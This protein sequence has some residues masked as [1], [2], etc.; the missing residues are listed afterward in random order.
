M[1]WHVNTCDFV[2][3]VVVVVGVDILARVVF[4]WLVALSKC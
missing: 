1:S 4:E 3:V 2:V